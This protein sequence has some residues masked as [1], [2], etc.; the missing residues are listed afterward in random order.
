MIITRSPVRISFGG[1]GTDMPT[2][3]NQFGGAV[4]S[5]SINKYIYSI[6]CRRPDNK[7][8]LISSNYQTTLTLDDFYSI[9]F[10][11]GFDIPCAVIKKFE[12]QHGFDLFLASEIPPGSGLGSSGSVTV[13]LIGLCSRLREMELSKQEIAEKAYHIQRED[14]NLPIG[15]QDEYG[16]AL[17]GLNF[18][19]FK[20]DGVVVEPVNL[21]ENTNKKLQKNL[22]L[23][24]TGQ[25]RVA[26]D[27]LSSQEDDAAKSV[28]GV[29]DAMHNVK[30]NA[31]KMR[32]ALL[33]DDL[34]RFGNLLD[35]A[36]IQKRRMNSKISN[37]KIDAAYTVAKDNGA[38]GGKL[39]GAGGGGYLLFY[40]EEDNQA[41]LIEAL[42]KE[43]MV[44]L[45]FSFDEQGMVFVD[46]IMK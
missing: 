10:G 22:L 6:Y 3:F 25:T 19:E 5:T 36:W 13:N 27:I 18:I 7:I 14:L 30:Q 46:Q 12:V 32:E 34:T 42:A 37:E 28:G 26:A 40:C 45:D 4:L 2:Y 44:N 8:Q 31:Y 38:L 21:S 16:A 35:D 1:G 33:A 39:T 20:K 29:L 11:E 17:G 24:F 15:K 41:K 9:R 23:F 43:G